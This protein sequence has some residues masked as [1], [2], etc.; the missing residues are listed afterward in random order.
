M[1]NSVKFGLYGAVLAGM[2]GGTAAWATTDK[3]VVVTVD[4]QARTIHTRSATVGGALHEAHI[5][6]AAHDVV[7]PAADTQ[8][9]DGSRVVLRRGRLLH[10]DVD[11][12]A[13]DVW[14]TASTVNEALAD[15]GYGT[16][17]AVS[18]SRSTRLPLTPTELTLLTPKSV[19]V[20]TRHRVAHLL[21]T[22]ATVAQ[23]IA[24]ARF[25]LGP[26]DR[27][28]AQVG[29][30]PVAGP[31]IRIERVSYRT[32]YRQ[33]PVP[34]PTTSTKDS[35]RFVGSTVVVTAG[36]PGLKKISYR[37][38]YVDG[39]L[40]SKDRGRT[41]TLRAPV[42]EQRRVGTKQHPVVQGSGGSGDGSGGGSGGGSGSGS[43]SG[44]GG[45]VPSGS[46]QSIASDMV[47]ARGWDGSQFSCLVS[48]WNRES[49]WSTTAANPSGA[50]GI[51]QALPGSKMASAGPDWQ[52]N[53]ATQ[54]S[55][56]LG[57]ISSRYGTPCGAWG[58]SQST[59][60]Y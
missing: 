20:M 11:G 44:S 34:F 28:S 49:G 10:L 40:E 33:V 37:F 4:G 16:N 51:P 2:I 30:P 50:Y 25:R 35:A 60:W 41:V 26:H 23:V 17:K 6:M 59:G 57:Y 24:D 38:V 47:A 5:G 36:R 31:K 58:H 29:G 27:V 18:V 39:K 54:I 56:G 12:R 13:V 15:L 46:A 7:A 53:A 22:R 48:L 1:R 45:P 42:A 43:G 14:T 52:N 32:K 19:T 21:T 8:V 55:W 3:T 9:H